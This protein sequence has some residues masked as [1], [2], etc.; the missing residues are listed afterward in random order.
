MRRREAPGPGDVL[1]NALAVERGR[2]TPRILIAEVLCRCD[3]EGSR[4]FVYD[5][6]GNGYLIERGESYWEERE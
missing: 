6:E 1:L 3:R 5:R 4:W 2:D